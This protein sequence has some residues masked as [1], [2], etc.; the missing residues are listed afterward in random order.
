MATYG[1][2]PI[3]REHSIEHPLERRNFSG[4]FIGGDRWQI[5]QRFRRNERCP[6]AHLESLTI[7]RARPAIFKSLLVFAFTVHT[8]FKGGMCVLKNRKR[9][10]SIY[11]TPKNQL[12][13]RTSLSDIYQAVSSFCG[14]SSEPWTRGTPPSS[15]IGDAQI[16]MHGMIGVLDPGRDNLR[17]EG[18]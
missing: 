11:P 18:E 6:V 8:S 16:S 13:K 10:V 12:V 17:T 9:G 4:E 7:I 15:S 3:F 1:I 5:R 14:Y 2:S